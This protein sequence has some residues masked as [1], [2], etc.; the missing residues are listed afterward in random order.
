M[1]SSIKSDLCGLERMRTIELSEHSQHYIV[2]SQL[3]DWVANVAAPLASGVL[4]DYGCGGQPYKSTFAP[5]IS[6]YIGADVTAALGVV[7]DI[8]LDVIG[9]VPLPNESVDTILS[10]Q[11]LEHIYDFQ[12]YL[13][14]SARLLRPLG[15]LVISVPM[16]W[17]H[18]EVPYDYWRFTKYGL[19]KSLESSGFRIVDIRPCG[20]VYSLLG[21]T[22]LDHLSRRELFNQ[23]A[24]K[25][26]NRIALWLDKKMM[27]TEDT[28]G[29]MCI[30]EKSVADAVPNL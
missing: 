13:A 19:V 7:L 4:L 29:W 26:I 14:D 8:E 28:L 16:H 12:S 27:D 20:G 23:F 17:R 2:L 3:N 18:H 11:V 9:Q 15:R 21:Q 1:N 30:A 6:K 10:T 5:Y 25:M 24:S 22:L